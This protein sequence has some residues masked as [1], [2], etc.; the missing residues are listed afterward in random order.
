[1]A[2]M[3]GTSIR[4]RAPFKWLKHSTLVGAEAMLLVGAAQ[5]LLSQR[6]GA[7]H[8]PNPL[9]ILVTMAMVLGV[10]TGL[11]MLMRLIATKGMSHT[12]DVAKALP[13]PAATVLAH[14]AA[15]AC[16]FLLYAVVWHLPFE[17]PGVGTI[18]EPKT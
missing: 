16:L 6:M 3:P 13:I 14:L 5:Q 12:H 8:M 11:N 9:R 10:L 2:A 1:M 4:R 18:G 7:V 17:I 15:F